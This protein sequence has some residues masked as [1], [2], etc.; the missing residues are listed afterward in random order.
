MFVVEA[1]GSFHRCR[2]FIDQHFTQL[3]SLHEIAE[4]LNLR[5]PYLCRLFRKMGYPSP[6][7]YLTHKKL[8]RAAEMLVVDGKSVKEVAAAVG[9]NDAY[10][11]SRVFKAH[12]GKSPTHFVKSAIGQN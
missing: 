10:H 2:D 9:Y 8:A 6:F 4:R 12:Y 3:K 11:F 7:Q 1:S 5:S